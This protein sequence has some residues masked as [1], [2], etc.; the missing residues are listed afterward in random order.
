[1]VDQGINEFYQD[2]KRRAYY[3]QII[4]ELA[5][6]LLQ[7]SSMEDIL[8]LVAKSAIAQLGF[9]DCVIY[10]TDSSGHRLIQRAAH[11]PKNPV[12]KEILDPIII[13]V[14]E[15]I[16]GAV[17]ATGKP[18]LVR[19]T[20]TDERYIVDD[21][22]RLSELAVPIFFESKVIGVI[23]SEHPEANFYTPE[24]LE[25]MTTIA[26]MAATKIASAL[27]IERL[28]DTVDELHKAQ[29]ELRYQAAHDPLTGLYNRREFE[30]RLNHALLSARD[31]D[32]RHVLGYLDID[33]FKVVNDT[34]GHVAGDN[35]LRQLAKLFQK[36]LREDDVVARLG[37]DEFALLML[38]CDLANAHER[39]EQLR[40][41]VEDFRFAWEG[42]T[43]SVAVSIGLSQIDAQC[44]SEDVAL[45][46]AD[47]ACMM[48]KESGRNR[49]QVYQDDSTALHERYRAIHWVHRLSRAL[50]EKHFQFVCQPIVP[51]DADPNANPSYE[52]LL[53]LVEQDGN[54]IMPGDFLPAAERFGL[55][56]RLDRYV[57]SEV[58]EWLA[59]HRTQLPKSLLVSINI[60]AY[61]LDSLELYEHIIGELQRTQMPGSALCI[62]ITETAAIANHARSSG[63]ISGLKQHGC[64]FAIDDFGS[65]MTTVGYLRNLPVDYIKLDGTLIRRIID[66]PIDRK[67]VQAIIHIAHMLG[68]KTVAEYVETEHALILLKKMG[69]DCVQGFLV[70]EPT[71]LSAMLVRRPRSRTG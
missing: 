21:E 25:I 52:V 66:D 24:H 60:S 59:A 2:L 62:E 45:S 70:G 65:G 37:G 49:V 61:S 71:P 29:Q 34:S 38:D 20:R 18:Q 40:H 41:R 46:M 56:T 14:G 26:S 54:F 17:A 68:V 48:A 42:Q 50:D 8:W 58:L 44:T 1:M 35:L 33:L 23:D 3:L 5:L 51:V 22:S 67:L 19:D 31:D 4:N 7:Q 10:L 28:H 63:F 55:S 32:T 47:T 6:G 39:I 15:G 16:V 36:V 69:I 12:A 9:L 30:L 11:G 27:A 53:R 57:I 13:P 64:R 43:L